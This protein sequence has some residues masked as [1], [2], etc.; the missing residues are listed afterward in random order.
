LLF[1]SR[2]LFLNHTQWQFRDHTQ[3]RSRN[4]TQWQCRN[5]TQWQCRNRSQFQF[6]N[7]IR[8]HTLFHNR[9]LFR[10][11]T[12]FH[13]RLQCQAAGSKRNHLLLQ[14]CN[15]LPRPHNSVDFSKLHSHKHPALARFVVAI[16][17]TKTS[18][19]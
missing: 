6:R 10:N 7:R 19:I 3:C 17:T 9:C 8:N 13:S 4:H 5:H 14:L 1:R 18:P 11:H 15:L 2:S 12:L 16:Q